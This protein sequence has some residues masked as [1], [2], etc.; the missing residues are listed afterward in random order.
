[1]NEPTTNTNTLFVVDNEPMT[2]G[3]AMTFANGITVSV[4]WGEANYCDQTTTAEVAAYRKSNDE[5]GPVWVHAEGFD[6]DG[7]DV[8]GHL[9]PDEVARFIY[10]VSII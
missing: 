5:F 1:M 2:R 8:L 10:I 9:S 4:R 3:F 7:D 6:Y